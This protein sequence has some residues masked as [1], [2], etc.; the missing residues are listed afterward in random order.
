MCIHS[1][2]DFTLYPVSGIKEFPIYVHTTYE[3]FPKVHQSG[4]CVILLMVPQKGMRLC[5]CTATQKGDRETFTKASGIEE[6]K[7]G[8]NMVLEVSSKIM[9]ATGVLLN[10]IM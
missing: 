6:E 7:D 2:R 5:N 10:S 3:E 9:Q 8:C 1:C 4:P